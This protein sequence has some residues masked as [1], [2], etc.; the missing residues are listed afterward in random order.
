MRI[1]IRI[2]IIT[3]L[4]SLIM[5]C[6]L[7][8]NVLKNSDSI[9]N[10]NNET[11][12]TNEYIVKYKDNWEMLINYFLRGLIDYN[13]MPLSKNFCQKYNN[14]RSIVPGNVFGILENIIFN[15]TNEE[16]KNC[17]TIHTKTGKGS[18]DIAYLLHYKI[19]EKNELDDI[20]ILDSRVL[21]DE[22]GSYMHYD[23]YHYYSENQVLATD[24]LCFPYRNDFDGDPYRVYVTNKFYE[25]FPYCQD[26]KNLNDGIVGDTD[27]LICGDVTCDKEQSNVC[28]AKFLDVD[29]TKTYKITYIIADNG[30][31]DD[32][33]IELYKKEV[34]KDPEY[35]KALYEGYKEN[36]RWF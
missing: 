9:K 24:I 29:Y 5:A 25:K 2:V 12:I 1:K 27:Y 7:I 13:E 22:N 16:L 11:I 32:A 10:I 28:Y 33:K 26:D 35:V 14:V 20:E 21:I 15:N 6:I 8:R 34:T 30:Y 17:M 36:V 23:E 3:F 19:N 18:E 31:I 4:V